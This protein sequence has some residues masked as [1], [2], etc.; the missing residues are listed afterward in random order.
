MCVMSCQVAGEYSQVLKVDKCGKK[1]K[2]SM[3]PLSI[4]DLS[5]AKLLY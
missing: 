4:Q 1:T 3:C 5:Q 2:V